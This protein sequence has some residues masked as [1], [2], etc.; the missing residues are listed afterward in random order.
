MVLSKIF[1]V[2]PFSFRFNNAAFKLQILSSHLAL[3]HLGSILH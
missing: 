2:K 3:Q 1:E